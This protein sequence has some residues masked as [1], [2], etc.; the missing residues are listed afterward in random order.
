MRRELIDIWVVEARLG[1]GGMG[2]VYRC[3]NRDA[4]RIQAAIKVL[5]TRLAD[6]GEVR[7]RFVREA[8]LLFE[9]DH[10]H[11]VKVRNIRMDSE[12]PF[13]E[14]AFVQGTSLR[15]WIERGPMPPGAAAR[16]IGQVAGAL[17]HCHAREVRHRDVKPDNILLSGGHATLV[18]FGIATEAN[19]TLTNG[20]GAVGTLSYTPPEW[21]DI[22]ADSRLWDA[23]S[24]G[25]VFYE[26]LTGEVAFPARKGTSLRREIVRI[27]NEKQRIACL[28]PGE[29]HPEEL[30]HLIRRL[31]ATEP[32][33]RPTALH[34]V[35][36]Q[37]AR[38]T[39]G[40]DD[41]HLVDIVT[42]AEPA[43]LDDG[44]PIVRSKRA[45]RGPDGVAPQA[46]PGSDTFAEYGVDTPVFEPSET[47]V[48]SLRDSRATRSGISWKRVGGLAAVLIVMGWALIRGFFGG[49]AAPQAVRSGATAQ[50]RPVNFVVKGDEQR[51]P[52]QILLDGKRVDR[53]APLT[54]RVAEHKLEVRMGAGCA[55][56][57][58]SECLTTTARTVAVLAGAGSQSLRA[59]LPDLRELPLQF[60]PV[61][62]E[63]AEVR[64]ADGDWRSPEGVTVRGGIESIVTARVGA[65]PGAGCRE[66]STAVTPPLNPDR[67][68]VASLSLV[69]TR[70]RAAPQGAPSEAAQ[71]APQEAPQ[72]SS[73]GHLIT[74][75]ELSAFLAKNPDFQRE[76]AKNPP[77]RYLMGWTGAEAPPGDSP[78]Q[79][80]ARGSGRLARAVCARRGGLYPA[81][82][83]P[84][85]WDGERRQAEYRLQSGTVVLRQFNGVLLPVDDQY[86][87]PLT[88]IRCVR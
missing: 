55:E 4:K 46:D 73:R 60:E 22:D 8:E 67:P 64:I 74:V 43:P 3:H 38:F 80:A 6:S 70:S 86:S 59:T 54:L 53:D 82:G 76:Q 88:V 15:K 77:A 10:P 32:S 56:A 62:P 63:G 72:E 41:L 79:A 29:G 58:S 83:V 50:F 26:L 20:S 30:R 45:A 39:D 37:L 25:I 11:I 24:L 12:P 28:D 19:G 81:D 71:S 35:A 14:M 44:A 31:T 42:E 34:E 66:A 48:A 78:T 36:E 16:V 40:R 57:Q 17:G 65:C 33:D 51:F 87:A 69:Q 75:R 84:L 68:V 7:R 47:A 9:L 52:V 21:G 61:L 18:D 5:D 13:I 23:Y 49:D 85:R 27:I 2:T 1:G